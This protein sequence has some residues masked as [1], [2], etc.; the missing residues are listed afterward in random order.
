MNL[1]DLVFA[2]L[3]FSLA[4]VLSLPIFLH[5]GVGLFTMCHYMLKVGN[6]FIFKK[7]LKFIIKRLICISEET[8]DYLYYIYILINIL[9][10][11]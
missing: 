4:L 9:H 2:L 8:S 3:G 10:I 5:F 1:Q 7:L 6:F 11:F